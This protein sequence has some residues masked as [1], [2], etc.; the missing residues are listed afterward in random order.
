MLKP[1]LDCSAATTYLAQCKHAVDAGAPILSSPAAAPL[2]GTP[3]FQTAYLHAVQ[4]QWEIVAQSQHTCR[5]E[6]VLEQQKQQLAHQHQQLHR[7]EAKELQRQQVQQQQRLQCQ[8]EQIVAAVW[9]DKT[10]VSW[11]EDLL[12]IPIAGFRAIIATTPGITPALF[13]QLKLARK[14]KRNRQYARSS[15]DRSRRHAGPDQQV[16]GRYA[17]KIGALQS[18]NSAL[19]SSLEAS[20][21]ASAPAAHSSTNN[22]R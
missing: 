18:F 1:S 12:D 3:Q 15:R 5:L 17:Q 11:P 19:R 16:R 6:Q 9:L 7:L 13:D 14:R 22:G 10:A 4:Q 20:Q 2:A 8:Q 21:R